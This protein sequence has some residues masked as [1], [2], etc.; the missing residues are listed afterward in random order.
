MRPS[1]VDYP[2]DILA[3]C[4]K[5]AP[6]VSY[7]SIKFQTADFVLF[8]LIFVLFLPRNAIQCKAQ[9]CDRMSSVRQSVCPSVT[10]TDCD[11]IGWN[12]SKIVSRSVSLRCSPS[13]D[14]PNITFAGR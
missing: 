13:A 9:S 10:L 6:P 12:S 4:F 3:S 5:V 8:V 2:C 11:D 14:D 1:T 7:I